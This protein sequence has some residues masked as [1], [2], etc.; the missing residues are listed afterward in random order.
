MSGEIVAGGH[1]GHASCADVV[2]H[3]RYLE[4]LIKYRCVGCA[5]CVHNDMGDENIRP[6]CRVVV[7]IEDERSSR[8]LVVVVGEFDRQLCQSISFTSVGSSDASLEVVR[9]KCV[10]VKTSNNAKVA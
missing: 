7:V 1:V 10:Y 9:R 8:V 5:A 6:R 3:R 4:D 2:E